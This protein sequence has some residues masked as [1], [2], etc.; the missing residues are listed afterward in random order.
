MPPPFQSAENPVKVGAKGVPTYVDFR[1]YAYVEAGGG[2]A[3]AD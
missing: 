2:S 3:A 1:A